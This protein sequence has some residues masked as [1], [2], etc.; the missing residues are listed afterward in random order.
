M[1]DVERQALICKVHT[2]AHTSAPQSS[3]FWHQPSAAAPLHTCNVTIGS[4]EARADVDQQ[5]P[6]VDEVGQRCITRLPDAVD[7]VTCQS[8]LN[9]LG[10]RERWHTRERDAIASA[11]RRPPMVAVDATLPLTGPQGRLTLLEAFEGAPTAH[12]LLPSCG[13]PANPRRSSAKAAP[14]TPRRSPSCPTSILATSPT[15]P[16]VRVPTTRASA[17]ATSSR[18]RLP[19][20]HRCNVGLR[21]AHNTRGAV[22]LSGSDG[23]GL[24][25]AERPAASGL[26]LGRPSG[27]E[28]NV[29]RRSV[30]QVPHVAQALLDKGLLKAKQS[31]VMPPI[32]TVRFLRQVKTLSRGLNER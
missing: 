17:I 29:P 2:R 4:K 32:V 28:P 14:S 19:Q 8:E 5:S 30:G 11:R 3:C 24:Q 1:I 13:T 20:S 22:F 31:H 10:I 26:A 6:R 27:L 25:P 21:S 16:S 18:T 9:T 15:R 7:R 23:L 12:R